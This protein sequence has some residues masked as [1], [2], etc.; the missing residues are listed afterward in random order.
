MEEDTEVLDWGHE[1]DEQTAQ[2]GPDD[3]ED[4]VSLGGDEDDYYPYPASEQEA[5]KTE[6]QFSHSHSTP[7]VKRDSVV[8]RQSVAPQREADSPQLRRSQ[9]LGKFTHALPPKPVV[10]VAPVHPSPAQAS[11]LASSMIQRERRANGHGK[12]NSGGQHDA[13]PPDWELRQARSGGGEHYYY[14]S[15]THESTWTRPVSGKSSPAKDSAS[16]GREGISPPSRSGDSPE[17]R[18]SRKEPKRSV[19]DLSYEDRHYRPAGSAPVVAESV[20]VSDQRAPRSPVQAAFA[21]PYEAGRAPSPR[22]LPERRR[23]RSLSPLRRGYP[24]SARARRDPSPERDLEGRHGNYV[25]RLSPEPPSLHRHSRARGRQDRMDVDVSPRNTTLDR[26]PANRRGPND[27]SAPSTLSASSHLSSP[28]CDPLPRWRTWLSREALG[29]EYCYPL[30]PIPDLFPCAAQGRSSR[31]CP[32]TLYPLSASPFVALLTLSVFILQGLD[33]RRHTRARHLH[34]AQGDSLA[35]LRQE[36]RKFH[37]FLCFRL[38]QD[39]N[40]L[41]GQTNFEE[42][43]LSVVT[44][45]TH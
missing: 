25:S 21:E 31:S 10:S 5:T 45:T 42:L 13:L 6:T 17:Q 28:A 26:E 9:S 41:T 29:V 32:F 15:R 7:Q 3:A 18:T 37:Q 19:D 24:N 30:L 2:R 1:D 35:A 8:S 11:T 38:L 22:A 36:V 27:W 43:R 44:V 40:G 12:P 39:R 14:N 33:R 4:A 34:P 16:R 20:V 23:T